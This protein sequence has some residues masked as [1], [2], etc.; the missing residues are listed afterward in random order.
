L[1]AQCERAELGVGDRLAGLQIEKV[2][3]AVAEVVEVGEGQRAHP[4][5]CGDTRVVGAVAPSLMAMQDAVH[6]RAAGPAKVFV[7]PTPLVIAER[8][9]RRGHM[10]RLPGNRARPCMCAGWL[11]KCRLAGAPALMRP[12]TVAQA[13]EPAQAWASTGIL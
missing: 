12:A 10:V 7:Q 11:F 4:L 13:A 3:R 8:R 5:R 2:G 6:L 1:A 9:E